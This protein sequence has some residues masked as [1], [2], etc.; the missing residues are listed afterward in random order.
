MA[1]LAIRRTS[2]TSISL[3][4][5][6]IASALA[7]SFLCLSPVMA[8][9]SAD[10]FLCLRLAM[11]LSRS[12]FFVRANSKTR[13]PSQSS[14]MNLRCSSLSTVKFPNVKHIRTH[15][16]SLLL[17]FSSVCTMLCMFSLVSITARQAGYRDNLLKTRCTFNKSGCWVGC[18]CSREQIDSSTS[19]GKKSAWEASLTRLR[20]TPQVSANSLTDVA[21]SNFSCCRWHSG[22]SSAPKQETAPSWTRMLWFCSSSDKLRT[23][24][25]R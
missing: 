21:G 22:F 23:A 15:I 10:I 20:N 25:R 8:V 5:R 4:S 24:P 6:S 11:R 19:S 9:A 3:I 16:D 18:F 14:A 13:T 7:E 1:K 12:Q 17:C 2:F